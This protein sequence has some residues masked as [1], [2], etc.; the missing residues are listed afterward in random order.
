MGA[1]HLPI[2]N[3]A[4]RW[5]QMEAAIEFK[6]SPEAWDSHTAEDRAT[7]VARWL[8]VSIRKQAGP[9][10]RAKERYW[11]TSGA[12]HFKYE[13]RNTAWDRSVSESV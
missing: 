2:Q 3:P 9:I 7:M 4:D 11:S 8:I 6:L 10:V 12:I 5:T 1:F 13:Y